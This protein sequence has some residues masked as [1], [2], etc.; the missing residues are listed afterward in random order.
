[1]FLEIIGERGSSDFRQLDSSLS[2]FEPGRLV[3]FS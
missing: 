3:N 2:K 1:M